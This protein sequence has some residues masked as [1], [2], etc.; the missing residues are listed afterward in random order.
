MEEIYSAIINARWD[1]KFD[2]DEEIGHDVIAIKI[3]DHECHIIKGYIKIYEQ[4]VSRYNESLLNKENTEDYLNRIEAIRD[5]DQKK[6]NAFQEILK[7][8]LRSID[9]I[10][11]NMQKDNIKKV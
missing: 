5:V 10:K 4:S 9:S 7:N 8:L 2:T 11:A 1:Q 6:L 3:L